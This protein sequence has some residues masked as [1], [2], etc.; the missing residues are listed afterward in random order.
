MDA[1]LLGVGGTAPVVDFYVP[2]A[3]TGSHAIPIITGAV[4]DAQQ[5]QVLVALILNGIPQLPGKGND[6]L[7]FMDSNLPFGQALGQL[8]AQIRKS[9]AD[10]GHSDFFPDYDIVNDTIVANAVKQGALS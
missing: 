5:A 6:W 8:D 2:A 7:G 4:E 1:Q 10:G 9:L 3:T